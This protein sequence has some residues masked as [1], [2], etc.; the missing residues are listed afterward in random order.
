[1]PQLPKGTKALFGALA[2]LLVSLLGFWAVLG[3]ATGAGPSV[4]GRGT[5]LAL[6]LFPVMFVVSAFLNLWVIFVPLSRRASAFALGAIVP[7]VMLV[8]AY[9]YL[10]GTWPLTH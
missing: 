9:S 7:G 8:L 1:M 3:T 6:I 10:W 2:P 4:G 5:V